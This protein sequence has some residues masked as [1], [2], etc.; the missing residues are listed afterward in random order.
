MAGSIAVES[1]DVTLAVG[2]AGGGAGDGKLVDVDSSGSIETRG[3]FAYGIL[4]QS[5]GGG[6]GAGGNT[7]TLSFNLNIVDSLEDLIP[8]PGGSQNVSLGGKSGGGGN[9]GIVD[10]T[11]RARSP[12]RG[13]W[14]TE[15][16]PRASAA[17]AAP[18]AIV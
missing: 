3:D 14:L 15:F 9:G 4:A 8:T 1:I 5:V 7:T 2:G 18:A 12:R 11:N 10:V 17:A 13:S 16:W 6:G